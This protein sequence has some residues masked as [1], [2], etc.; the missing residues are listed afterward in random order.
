M[1]SQL[2]SSGAP[3][4]S[5]LPVIKLIQ[6]YSSHSLRDQVT[7]IGTARK[8]VNVQ[9]L[10]EFKFKNEN[11]RI[12]HSK[13]N[14]VTIHKVESYTCCCWWRGHVVFYD[15]RQYR[16]HYRFKIHTYKLQRYHQILSELLRDPFKLRLHYR[17]HD[18][19]RTACADSRRS[20][21][22]KCYHVE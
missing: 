18:F 10:S 19:N 15:L 7:I 2:F 5:W 17:I 1:P 4:V 16:H 22:L 8:N 3:W 14:D 9:H 20:P 12:L 6:W 21:H 11:G 13:S